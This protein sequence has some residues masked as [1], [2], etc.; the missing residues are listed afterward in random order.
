MKYKNQKIKGFECIKVKVWIEN[1]EIK[2]D[3]FS[4]DAEVHSSEGDCQVS[5]FRDLVIHAIANV[6]RSDEQFDQITFEDIQGGNLSND[7]KSIGH[8]YYILNL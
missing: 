4:C 6:F 3:T 5:D 8:G 7:E 2:D 1:A